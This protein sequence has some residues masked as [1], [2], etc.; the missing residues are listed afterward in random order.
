MRLVWGENSE[1]WRWG[2]MVA[3]GALSVGRG[4]AGERRAVCCLEA[5]TP[6]VCCQVG[7]IRVASDPVAGTPEVCF[8]ADGSR[9]V[10]DPV[11]GS[12]A[13]CFLEAGTPEAC[14]QVDGIRVASDLVDGSQVVCFPEA[15]IRAAC[16]LA[17]GS[18]AACVL[19]VDNWGGGRT[20]VV[21]GRSDNFSR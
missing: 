7:G 14:C 20:A 2:A 10:F 15:G 16:T 8:P 21:A 11:A 12:Q 17:A 9:G 18:R 5:E 6:E 1:A 4:A 13:V 19:A 3:T